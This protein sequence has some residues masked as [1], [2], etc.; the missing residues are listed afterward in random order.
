LG[1]DFIKLVF[2]RTGCESI[3]DYFYS[4][5]WQEL[6]DRHLSLQCY[7]CGERKYLSLFLTNWMAIGQER[8]RDVVTL[9]K[10]C[11]QAI[12]EMVANKQAAR[13]DAHLLLRHRNNLE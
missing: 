12:T 10:K 11:E 2:E 3:R 5:R 1:G 8:G 13:K 4:E 9:C 6:R 7:C